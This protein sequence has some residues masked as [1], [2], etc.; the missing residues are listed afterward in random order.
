MKHTMLTGPS[1][2]AIITAAR[3][4]ALD[5]AEALFRAGGYDARGDDP[6]A[7]AV[8]GR[9]LKDR[10]FLSAAG[11]RAT[12]LRQ[13]ADA[14]ARADRLH[15]QPYTRINAA[16]LLLLGGDA[17]KAQTLAREVL[18]W[19]DSG[20][21]IAETPWFL[22]A[23]RAE[24]HLLLGD[25]T[26]AEQALT[27]AAATGTGDWSDRATTLRQFCQILAAHGMEDGWFTR[28]AAPTSLH[29]AG[30]LG[31]AAKADPALIA[32]I[33]AAL[34]ELDVGFGFG[35]LAAGSEILIA[36][37]LLARGCE[38]EV[39]LPTSV[40]EFAAQSVIPH[41]ADWLERYEHCLDAA[42]SV[43]ETAHV[44]GQY[45]PLASRLA[46]EVAMGAACRHARHIDGSAA[47]LV[48]LDDG[49]GPWGTGT[50]TALLAER[51]HSTGRTQRV[52]RSPRIAAVPA[53]GLRAEP[54]GRR[55]RHLFALLRIGFQ[56]LDQLDEGAFAEAVDAVLAPF[57]NHVAKLPV[58]PELVLPAGNARLV[59]FS[60]PEAAWRFA[61][62]AFA[63]PRPALPLRIAGHYGL[64]HRLDDPPALVGRMIAQLDALYSAALPGVLTVS[65]SFASALS[66]GDD[67]GAFA[68]WIGESGDLRVYTVSNLREG[69]G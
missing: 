37:R 7:L 55:D 28:F 21:P 13:A 49:A 12:L 9:L 52:I 30:H 35:A 65:E 61:G 39:V 50:G 17:M 19:L 33:D 68:E 40:A 58:H 11:E 36:E 26:G 25:L 3:A 62:A 53:S 18:A 42:S 66:L 56:G 54:E 48:I 45:E 20:K 24:A 31:L 51:W 44:S 14:Y 63:L 4:G 47:Q 32:Q 27:R 34:D 10:A 57:R 2:A 16:T 67:G 43:T 5:H 8:K 59:A 46:S 1:L 41:G 23:I 22:E 29:F 15:A 38:L 60:T 6:A 69:A 64:A